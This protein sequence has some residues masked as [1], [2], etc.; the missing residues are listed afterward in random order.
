MHT[1][2][3]HLHFA[4]VGELYGTQVVPISDAIDYGKELL[5]QPQPISDD[6]IESIIA[7]N[8]DYD[9]ALDYITCNLD[10]DVIEDLLDIIPETD[11]IEQYK[12]TDIT[13][14]GRHLAI[15]DPDTATDLLNELLYWRDQGRI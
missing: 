10:A 11:L 6:Q 5:E 9:T 7:K 2:L 14:Y 8:L 1:P 3:E 15:D 4:I 13:T 12:P